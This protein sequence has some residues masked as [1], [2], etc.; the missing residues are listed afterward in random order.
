MRVLPTKWR[1]KPADIDMER[2]DATVTLCIFLLIKIA[3]EVDAKPV[4][5]C[6][7]PVTHA[8]THARTDGQAE[9]IMPPRPV[10]WTAE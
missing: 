3:R 10:G 8:H 4:G 6:I 9:N 5:K 1:R 2:N 7:C